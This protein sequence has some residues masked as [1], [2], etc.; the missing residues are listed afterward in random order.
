MKNR[1]EIIK[2]PDKPWFSISEIIKEG[3][4]PFC[5]A[6]LYNWIKS[7][8]IPAPTQL[9]CRVFYRREIILQILDDLAEK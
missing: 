7:G 6:T 3:Y 1:H 4:I 9:G 2:L 8:V 5:K